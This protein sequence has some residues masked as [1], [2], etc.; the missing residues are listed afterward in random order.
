M[1]PTLIHIVCVS[2]PDAGL[3]FLTESFAAGRLFLETL[4]RLQTTNT[5]EPPIV[6]ARA[7]AEVEELTR[8]YGPSSPGC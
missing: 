4:E 8:W 1:R 3:Q 7:Q 2:G 6:S 5:P